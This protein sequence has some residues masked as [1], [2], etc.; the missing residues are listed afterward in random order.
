MIAN[1]PYKI[2]NKREKVARRIFVEI[3][4]GIDIIEIERLSRVLQK[5]RERFLKRIYT[6][7]EILNLPK[8]QKDLYLSISFSF[9]ES[10]WKSLPSS[11]QQKTRFKDIEIFWKGETPEILIQKNTQLQII[12]HH[13]IT[14]GNIITLS[15]FLKN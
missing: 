2:Y 12:T 15:I 3:S 9:K 11:L 7:E 5:Q 8:E 13:F 10:V 6:E 4:V 14:S 1:A